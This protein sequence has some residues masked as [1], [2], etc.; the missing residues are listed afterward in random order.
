MWQ[1]SFIQTLPDELLRWFLF[2]I[3]TA[4]LPILT[5]GVVRKT[6][7]RMQGRIGA[8]L[9][10]AYYDIKKL[11]RKSETVSSTSSWIFRSGA[12]IELTNIILIASMVPWICNKPFGIS[13]DLFLVIYL[14]ALGRLFALLAALDSGSPFGAFGSSRD[15]TL[16]MLVEPASLLSLASLA[17]ISKSTELNTIFSLPNSALHPDP[18]IWILAGTAIVMASLVELSRMPVDDPATHLELT[19]IHEAMILESSGR[20]LALREYTRALKM[21][22]LF[23]LATQCYLRSW[24]TFWTLPVLAQVSASIFGILLLAFFVG[25]F[26]S[27]SVKLQWRKVPE[28]ISYC[29][30]IS[31]LAAMAAVARG[32]VH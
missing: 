32:I 5:I 15:A 13:S 24:E 8:P 7:A 22:V 17:I 23:G 14:F 10:Q 6:R 30:T 19:M 3:I 1:S 11:L 28:F 25:I 16:A 20:N 27:V 26:E 9:L 12:G 31:L 2:A 18:G 29:M 4:I 21:T